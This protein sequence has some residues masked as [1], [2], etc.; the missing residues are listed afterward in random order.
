MDKLLNI[1]LAR[2]VASTV[3]VIGLMAASVAN[4]S[5]GAPKPEK[6]TWSFNGIFGTFDRGAL[7]RGYQVYSEVCVSC[8]GLGLIAYRNLMDIGFTEDE[9]KEIAA[10]FEVEDGP[11]DEGEM[12]MRPAILADHLVPPYPNTNAARASNN[13]A[14]PPDLS[15][16]AKARIGGPDYL[17]ALMTGYHEEAPEGFE[18]S[19]DMSY[20][21]YFPGNQIAMGQPLE[22]E[23]VEYADGTSATL[24]QHAKDITTF[25]MWTASPELEERKRLG[26]KVILFLIIWTAMLYALKVKIWARLH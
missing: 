20:N 23:M 10:E 3:L 7:K 21:T 5:S 6:Q 25:L 11:N 24:E 19:E 9:A 1:R 12:F 17:Y 13:G 15:L 2:T 4:A 16:M 8:H 22:D 26:V 18:L 14:L